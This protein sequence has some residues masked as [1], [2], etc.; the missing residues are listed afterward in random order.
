M[1]GVA[2]Q[3]VI[4]AQSKDPLEGVVLVTT[5][6]AAVLDVEVRAGVGA[7]PAATRMAA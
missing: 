3:S 2:E 5:E 4:P 7:A 1:T 6:G